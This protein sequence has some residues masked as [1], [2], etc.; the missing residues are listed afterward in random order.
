MLEKKVVFGFIFLI[1]SNAGVWL[2]SRKRPPILSARCAAHPNAPD[3]RWSFPDFVSAPRAAGIYT[4]SPNYPE[5]DHIRREL[6]MFFSTFPRVAE[7]FSLRI[8]GGGPQA[9]KPKLP[10]AAETLVE[11]GRLR[12]PTCL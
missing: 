8:W 7:C 2:H 11:R 4:I 1:A 9:G 3:W 12:S 6:D 10:P 5:R